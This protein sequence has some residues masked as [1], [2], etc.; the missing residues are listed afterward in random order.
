MTDSTQNQPD[1][2]NRNRN[3]DRVGA[4]TLAVGAGATTATGVAVAQD[5]QEVV[6]Q[7]RDY[8][9]NE[10]FTVLAKLEERNRSEF[11]D[12]LDDDDVFDDDDEDWD[13]YSVLIEVGQPAGQLVF[14][15]ID[16]D[17]DPRSGETGTMGDNASI[18]DAEWDLLE[19]DVT[20]DDADDDEED[21]D[22]G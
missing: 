22:A 6:V 18:H 11:I 16:N 15:L 2:P 10:P 9:P 21:G 7:S 19:V 12:E 4:A 14:M 8:F 13:V 17:V 20:L 5:Q 3:R 1:E